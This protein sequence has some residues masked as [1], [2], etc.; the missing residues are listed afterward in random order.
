MFD[1]VWSD[2][3]RAWSVDDMPEHYRDQLMQALEAVI[4]DNLEEE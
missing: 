4:G 2:P 3:H 1:D